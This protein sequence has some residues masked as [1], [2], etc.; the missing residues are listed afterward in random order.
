MYSKCIGGQNL[1]VSRVDDD[2][3]D[4]EQLFCTDNIGCSFR[5]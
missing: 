5:R 1:R 4:D 3:D 2:D